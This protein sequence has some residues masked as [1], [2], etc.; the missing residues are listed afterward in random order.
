MN[1]LCLVCVLTV[2]TFLFYVFMSLKSGTS[3]CLSVIIIHCCLLTFF[4]ILEEMSQAASASSLLY[5]FI[6][7]VLGL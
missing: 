1:V 4:V 2:T 6:G 3:T 7:S 5:I